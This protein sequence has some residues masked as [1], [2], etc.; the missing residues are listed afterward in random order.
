MKKAFY[1]LTIGLL[2]V[3]CNK[4]NSTSNPD[5]PAPD[6]NYI[7]YQGERYKTVT[8]KDGRTW[9]AENLRYIPEGLTPSSDKTAKTAGIFN[10][11]VVNEEHTGL[12]FSDNADVIKSQG[13]LYQSEVALGLKVGD[14]TTVEAAQ[15][16]EG[17]Q[18]ICPEGWHIPTLSEIMAIA[19]KCSKQT[20]VATA[21]YYV[22]GNC[23]LANLN[24]DGFNMNPV[25]MVSFQ[26]V[27]K[28]EALIQGWLSGFP[29]RI[30]ST[31]FC[32]S[33]YAAVV[34]NTSGDATSGIK[35]LQFYGFMPMTN[36]AAATDYTCNGSIL[37]FRIAAP[38]RCIKDK[39]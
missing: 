20:D 31:F 37:S 2:F 19:G 5:T 6:E 34:Y 28:T 39:K 12:V 14:L 35:N 10:P 22:N 18:G 26:D 25:G 15:A 38:V 9:M 1:F 11:L 33:S 17:V 32:G 8:L 21:A 16:L 29:D 7:V 30:T 24:A 13:Y 27:T 3:A 4:D 23:S 36:K